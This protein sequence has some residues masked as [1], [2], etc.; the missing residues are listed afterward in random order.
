MF[1]SLFEL[2]YIRSYCLLCSS[3]ARILFSLNLLVLSVICKN[4][5]FKESMRSPHISLCKTWPNSF[6][7][8][9]C[10]RLGL[11]DLYIGI[12]QIWV[13]YFS[14]FMNLRNFIWCVQIIRVFWCFE[15][16]EFFFILRCEQG[17]HMHF[18]VL[19]FLFLVSSLIDSLWTNFCDVLTFFALDLLKYIILSKPFIKYVL[20]EYANLSWLLGVF[21]IQQIILPLEAC[22]FVILSS[23]F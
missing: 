7:I 3:F 4:V 16:Q 22:Y 5:W 6:C 18:S 15:V 23:Y 13:V 17:W 20:F 21:W 19:A 1:R 9:I 8:I 10:W 12:C 14:L 2:K 11:C